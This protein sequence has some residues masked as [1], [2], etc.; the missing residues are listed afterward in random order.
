[1]LLKTYL[2][3]V[4]SPTSGFI[5]LVKGLYFYYKNKRMVKIGVYVSYFI[6]REITGDKNL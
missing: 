2:R 4:S 3:T 6:V 5:G 1:M